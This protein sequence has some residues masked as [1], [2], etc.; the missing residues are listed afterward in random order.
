MNH[1]VNPP[2]AGEPGCNTSERL[3]N[4]SSDLAG[5][6]P[7]PEPSERPDSNRQSDGHGGHADRLRAIVRTHY[8][9]L[10]RS[11]RRLGVPEG[12]VEDAAQ[13]V[14][15]VVAQKIQDIVPGR[16]K[17]FLFGVALRVAQATRRECHKWREDTDERLL[18]EAPAAGLD[19]GEELD[20]RR[21]RALLDGLLASMPLALRT[22]FILYELEELT[23]AE[24]ARTL[25]IPSGTVASRLRR[26][27]E[28]FEALARRLQAQ[29]ARKEGGR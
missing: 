18:L 1:A 22:V 8:P 23:M 25:D 16:E 26:A 12:A 3:T 11:L 19:P 7:C 5:D 29:Q 2:L 27:R 24:I 28:S 10:W 17:T 6:T 15:W 4:A 14:I 9:F 21:A 13:K 20:E